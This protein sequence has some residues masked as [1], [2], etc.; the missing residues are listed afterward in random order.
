VIIAYHQLSNFSAI[1]WQEQVKFWWDD[2]D[3]RFVLDKRTESDFFFYG[4]SS[5][6]QQS[7]GRH[8]APLRHIILFPSQPVFTVT[9]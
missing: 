6:K 8:I 5:L 3:V 7:T 2:Y 9:P 4:A 1:S